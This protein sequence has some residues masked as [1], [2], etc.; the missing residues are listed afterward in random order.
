MLDAARPNLLRILGHNCVGLI[1][2]GIKLN[3]SFAHAP[4]LPGRL[5]FISQSGALCTAVL[6]WARTRGVGFSHFISL[7]N[8]ADVDFGDAIDYLASEPD[9]QAIML[10]IESITGARKFMS[11]AR[12]AARNKPVIV[13]KAGRVAEGARAAMSHTGAM[14]GSDDAY[15]AAL[16]RAGMLRVF[17]MD[18]LFDAVE[19]LAYSRSLGGERLVILTNGGG[20]GVLAT[21]ELVVRGGRLAQLGDDTLARLDG[22]LPATWSRGNPVD[23]IGDATPERFL[24][25]IDVLKGS[26]ETDAVLFTTSPTA[27]IDSSD[28]ARAV[29]QPLKNLGRPIFASLLGGDSM[30]AA[31]RVFEAAGIPTYDT[32]EK[33]VRAFL[34]L[35]EY[36]RNQAALMETPPSLALDTPPDSDAARAVILAAL[37]DGRTLLSEPEAKAVLGAYGIPTVDTRIAKTPAEAAAVAAR[38]GFPVALKVLS[39]DVTHKSDI[40]GVVLDLE[41]PAAV[42]AAAEAIRTRLETLKPGARLDGFTVQK[43]ARRVGAH[44]V[45]VGAALDPTFGPIILF[46]QGGTAV[47]VVKDRAVA[48]P[49]LNGALA[50]DLV[51]RTRVSRLLAGYRGRPPARLDAVYSVLVRL[52]Q[53]VADLPEVVEIDINPLLVDETGVIALDARM[54]VAKAT[55]VGAQRLS[56]R[57]YPQELEEVCEVGGRSV[58]L[59]P[60]RPEDE[61]QHRDF[62]ASLQPE[63]VR[64]R[65]F[66]Y[67]REF[68]AETMARWTQID[69]DREMAF[70]GVSRTGK[71]ETLGV[72]RAIADPDNVRAEF[73]I[74]VRSDQKGRGLGYALMTKM[75]RYLQG[76]G[77]RELFGQVLAHNERML[78]LARRLGFAVGHARGSD[79]YDVTLALDD[80]MALAKDRLASQT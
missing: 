40:G 45:I 37:R 5:A 36:R 27:L 23:I 69:Y 65:F 10:Y 59:R 75:I 42:T 79:I 43:M 39:P 28:L 3:A 78:A 41:S 20:P 26:Q 4:A 77:T 55:S 76:R 49:P 7:G 29:V 72:V 6:D 53:L 70:I 56:I 35:V 67:R 9:N 11:A 46:G 17:T 64:Y 50:R 52:S 73:A 63:D 60:I 61:P 62:L 22:V 71:S 80:G 33:A 58:L 21:D 47:E 13:V 15:D 8:G 19:T 1:V 31:R 57:P 24:A 2:P 30:G 44:E 38:I 48:L 18:E 14:A 51:A 25:A 66:S 68:N 32:P 34:H 54:G 74:I 12:A 16:R